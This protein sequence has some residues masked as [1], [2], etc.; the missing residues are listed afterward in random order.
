MSQWN[1]NWYILAHLMF[2]V[3]YLLFPLL[4]F[5]GWPNDG[6]EYGLTYTTSISSFT[7]LMIPFFYFNYNWAVPEFY[8][9]SKFKQYNLTVLFA[10]SVAICAIFL[11]VH[12]VEEYYAV[13][14]L[15]PLATFGIGMFHLVFVF[16][17]SLGIQVFKRWAIWEKEKLRLELSNLKMQVNPHF[18][19]NSLNN[20]YT[21]SILNS[22]KTAPSIASLS[23]IMKYVVYQAKNDFVPLEDEIGY[24]KDFVELQKIRMTTTSQ[25]D[26][27]VAGDLQDKTI[28][29]LLFI[30]FIENAFKYGISTE[31][32]T[33][34][35]IHIQVTESELILKC[36]NNKNNFQEDGPKTGIANSVHRLDLI[37]GKSYSLEIGDIG[38]KFTLDLKIP[39]K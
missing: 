12:W 8:F 11:I 22:E 27:K 6:D 25:L 19:F 5:P 14:C 4:V 16:T 39:L 17:I 24:I 3:C 10:M 9:H 15:T 34:I 29:P 35:I 28:H 38:E 21:L 1:K 23:S 18:L 32:D 7:V 13:D 30:A 33:L 26:F 36:E 2:W 37:Y 20:I 31:K